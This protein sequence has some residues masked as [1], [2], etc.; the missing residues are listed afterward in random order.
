MTAPRQST[1]ARKVAKRTAKHLTKREV[2]F[3]LI[4]TA[5]EMC[6]RGP[7]GGVRESDLRDA[8]VKLMG[9]LGGRRPQP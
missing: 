4:K 5:M 2:R 7:D 1:T 6:E 9:D 3:A 8:I